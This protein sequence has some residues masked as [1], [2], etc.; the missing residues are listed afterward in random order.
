MKTII[1]KHYPES[2]WV[3][4][5]GMFVCQHNGDTITE[6][7]EVDTM[8]AGEHDTYTVEDVLCADCGEAMENK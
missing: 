8:T 4:D 5:W 1:V 3:Y 7:N 6:I 2:T